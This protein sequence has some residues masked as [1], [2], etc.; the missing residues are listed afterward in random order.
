M[1]KLFTSIIVLFLYSGNA[2]AAFSATAIGQDGISATFKKFSFTGAKTKQEALD[3]AILKCRTALELQWGCRIIRYEHWND[4]TGKQKILQENDYSIKRYNKK[5]K[6]IS[7]NELSQRTK[8]QVAS[9]KVEK[10]NTNKLKETFKKKEKNSQKIAKEIKSNNKIKKKKNRKQPKAL[11]K[12]IEKEKEKYA[13]IDYKDV[14][15]LGTP[16]VITDLPEG[17]IKK[18]GTACKEFL[19]RTK[20]ATQI[21][22]KSFKRGEQY[23][24]RHPDNM[25]KAMAYFELFYMGNLRKNK[26][27]LESYKKNYKR[28]DQM[29]GVQKLMFMGTEKAVRGLIGTNKGRKSMR[30][31]LGMTIDLEP[32]TAIKRFWYLGELLGLGEQTKVKVSKE[33]KQRNEI[34]KRYQKTISQIKKQIEDDKEKEEKKEKK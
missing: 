29:N 20:K 34:I 7:T 32:A 19:C 23:N 16:I 22:G 24:A 18:F 4:N 12:I 28:K 11:K 10:K 33:M 6:K 27:K 5:I 9:K 25:I 26:S 13:A 3:S 14:L 21:M 2:N 1:K 30:E 8:A 15:E 17:M 31:A